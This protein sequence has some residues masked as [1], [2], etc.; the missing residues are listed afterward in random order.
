MSLTEVVF[1]GTRGLVNSDIL[2]DVCKNL[3]VSPI[4]PLRPS[5]QDN[6]PRVHI[7]SMHATMP[8]VCTSRRLAKNFNL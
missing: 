5:L 2:F 1:A 4:A 7:S 8:K 3:C 6:S